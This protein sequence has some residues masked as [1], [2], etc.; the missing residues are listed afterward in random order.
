MQM[1]AANFPCAHALNRS[2]TRTTAAR[3][4]HLLCSLG[5][6]VC[7]GGDRSL[8]GTAMRRLGKKRGGK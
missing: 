1:T 4:A 7:T 8:A 3:S 5:S 2:P 6:L